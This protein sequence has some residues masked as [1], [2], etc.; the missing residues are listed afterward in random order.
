M[1][2]IYHRYGMP[3]GGC[4]HMLCAWRGRKQST[5]SQTSGNQISED[6]LSL[7][8][9]DAGAKKK[10]VSYMTAITEE[11]GADYISPENRIPV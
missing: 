11:G 1:E 5:Q 9:K 6:A 3:S 10:L 7:W 8:T 4:Q 2:S